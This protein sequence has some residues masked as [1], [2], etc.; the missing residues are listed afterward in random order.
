M[1]EHSR[2]GNRRTVASE[3]APV[4]MKMAWQEIKARVHAY[5]RAPSTDTA[6]EVQR[7]FEELRDQQTVGTPAPTRQSSQPRGAGAKPA[8]VPA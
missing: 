3:P 8:R 5:A 6:F 2:P 1:T 7:A 4:S